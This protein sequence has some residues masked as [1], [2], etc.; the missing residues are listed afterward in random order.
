[1][2][3]GFVKISFR[4]SVD[5][6]FHLRYYKPCGLKILGLKP[7]SIN[8]RKRGSANL[9]AARPQV[10]VI[11]LNWN[12]ADDTIEC[13]E[14]VL[15][16]DYDNFSVVLVDNDSKD[17]SISR[18]KSWASGVDTNITTSFPDLVFP[19]VDKPLQLTEII[20]RKDM[21]L[22]ECIKSVSPDSIQGRT[23]ILVKNY[24]NA[25][26]A[27]ANNLGI[28]M[29]RILFESEYFFILN[30]DTVIERDCLTCLVDEMES[31]KNNG[32]A[33]SAVYLYSEPERIANTGGRI[34][35]FGSRKY[36]CGPIRDDVKKVTFVTG[37][38]LLMRNSV[39]EKVG[40]FSSRFFFGEEDF[41][42]CW[43]VKTNKIPLVCV[44]SSRVYHKV[45]ISAEKL[46]TGHIRKKFFYI[47]NRV[48]DMKHNLSSTTWQFWR[49]FL[50]VY[51]FLW[52][53]SKHNVKIP[54]AL[55][56]ILEMRR[57]TTE[58]D[59]ARRYTIETITQKLSF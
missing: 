11:V 23:L 43:R 42:F 46:M 26:F 31:D 34:T 33:T 27:I 32:A 18:I 4:Y 58:Y 59:D 9:N 56:F 52:L 53:T 49:F 51:S 3:K 57:Y 39:L 48:I 2:R 36:Y 1:M 37:C 45:G 7:D 21:T 47:F 5:K 29:S 12:G 28:E 40:L 20:L 35:F 6:I 25:G 17:D 30:N 13:L 55:K 8:I 38:A 41:E 10:S 15:K 19:K 50:L 24:E 14:S 44:T 22:E 16:I 54:T